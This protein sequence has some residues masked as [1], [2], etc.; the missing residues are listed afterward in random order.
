MSRV[1][2]SATIIVL[3]PEVIFVELDGMIVFIIG[4]SLENE[5]GRKSLLWHSIKLKDV[6]LA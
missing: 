2:E 4:L 3:F 5:E 6:H 1:H